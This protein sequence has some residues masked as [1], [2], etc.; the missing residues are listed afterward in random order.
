MNNLTDD[1]KEAIR[2]LCEEEG[3]PLDLAID[4]VQHKALEESQNLRTVLTSTSSTILVS[5]VCLMNTFPGNVLFIVAVLIASVAV[6][7][8]SVNSFIKLRAK[9]QLKVKIYQH[10]FNQGK[11]PKVG[12]D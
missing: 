10:P 8:T 5:C 4:I 9:R 7:I 2:K 11:N 6:F 1:Q 12:L 3:V